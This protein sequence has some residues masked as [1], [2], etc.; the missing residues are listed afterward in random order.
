MEGKSGRE[1][2]KGKCNEVVVTTVNRAS[3][4][5]DR[6]ALTEIQ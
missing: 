6:N 1:K 4:I 3:E 2:W 5:V